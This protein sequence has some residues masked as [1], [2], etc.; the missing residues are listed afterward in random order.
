MPYPGDFVVLSLNPL[1][2]VAHLDAQA[3]KEAAALHSARYIALVKGVGQGLPLKTKPT[4]EYLIVPVRDTG[5]PA[6]YPDD[7][8]FCLTPKIASQ[9]A[10]PISPYRRD[11][12]EESCMPI[13]PT[14]DFIRSEC[15]LDLAFGSLRVRVTTSRRDCSDVLSL[16]TSELVRLSHLQHRALEARESLVSSGGIATDFDPRPVPEIV[17]QQF[18][19]IIYPRGE[20]CDDLESISG[21]FEHDSSSDMHE[22]L[23]MDEALRLFSALLKHSGSK[24][25]PV[26]DVQYDLSSVKHIPDP[27]DFMRERWELY[28]I[29]ERATLRMLS[30]SSDS[31]S[32]E[33]EGAMPNERLYRPH[34]HHADASR[35]GL[36]QVRQPAE[37]PYVAP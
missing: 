9:L 33:S 26:V 17:N 31:S 21:I 8:R 12:E 37:S 18:S 2:S 35:P 16:P 15:E 32:E 5:R 11:G 14:A 10:L 23:D 29:V 19:P 1:L 13:V 30:G 4:N 20:D 24:N 27:S 25:V 7:A 22:S 36:Y 34:H 3:R 6:S 28:Q